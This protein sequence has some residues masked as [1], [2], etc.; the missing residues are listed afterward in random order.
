MNIQNFS[1]SI[2]HRLKLK[3][4]DYVEMEI[5][6]RVVPEEFDQVESYLFNMK[7]VQH[8]KNAFFFDQFL[9]TPDMAICRK[10]A[11]L[12]I[13]YKRNGSHVYLQ[14]KG[15]GFHSQ[16]ILYRS[17]FSTGKLKGALLEESHHD[18][19]Q[20]NEKILRQIL[21]EQVPAEMALAMKEHLGSN[22]LRKITR[23]TFLCIYRKQKFTVDLG[24]CFLEPSLD[25]VFAF[26]I[27]GKTMH[28]L[29]SFCEYEN[30]IKSEKKSLE[31]KIKR[32]PDLLNFDKKIAKRFNMP[33]EKLD[34]YHRCSSF[35]LPKNK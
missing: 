20:F 6:R 10:G 16:N 11:S 8:Q 1:Q 29:S 3:N 24:S 5:K 23:G 14:Y 34:K 27:A 28:P 31:S 19:V 26:H 13:R 30:E 33:V 4:F 25:R 15:P 17:E 32:I 21:I 35:F 2:C 7:G 18:I 12:R 9:D 22:I